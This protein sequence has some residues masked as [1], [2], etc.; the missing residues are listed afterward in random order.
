MSEPPVLGRPAPLPEEPPPTYPALIAGV[1]LVDQRSTRSLPMD[2]APR[3]KTCRLAPAE[4]RELPGLALQVDDH[5]LG[6]LAGNAV[7]VHPEV[8]LLAEPD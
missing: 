3:E 2:D 6:G 8:R 1:A 4:G 5:G 7:A